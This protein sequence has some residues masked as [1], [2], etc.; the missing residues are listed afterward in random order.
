[1]FGIKECFSQ[2]K[3]QITS[4]LINI[5]NIVE[6]KTYSKLHPTWLA[7]IYTISELDTS[8]RFH[9]ITKAPLM[10]TFYWHDIKTNIN[11]MAKVIDTITQ[12]V[13]DAR[14][15]YLDKNKLEASKIDSFIDVITDS[16]KNGESFQSLF[17]KYHM[18][19][20]PISKLELIKEGDL[21]PE[22]DLKTK[23]ANQGDIFTAYLPTL[24]CYLIVLK[25]VDERP[26]R[27]KRVLVTKF[28]D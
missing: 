9:D 26:I 17:A 4:D 28:V 20:D 8:K 10:E 23:E 12:H 11:F 22:L 24:N 13:W 14:F 5:E 25:T 27:F 6:A 16:Y 19:P 3:K 7:N 1:M 2:T 15:I 18:G 21:L